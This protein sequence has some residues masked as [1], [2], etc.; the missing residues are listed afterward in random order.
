MPVVSKR[1][2]L[3][4]IGVSLALI[5]SIIFITIQAVGSLTKTNRASAQIS[6]T[7][8]V[9]A[10]DP[11]GLPIYNK[12]TVV[13]GKIGQLLNK[14]KL[15]VLSTQNGWAFVTDSNNKG[16]VSSAA[17]RYDSVFPVHAAKSITDD[18][19]KLQR[20]TWKGSYTKAQLNA[21]LAPHFTQDFI[22][23]YV[24]QLFHPAGTTS[25]G[26]TLYAIEK[27][28]IYGYAIDQFDWAATQDPQPPMITHYTQNGQEVLIISQYHLNEESGNHMSTLYLTRKDQT[29]TWKVN[30]YITAY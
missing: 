27:T 20:K 21:M 30:D 16:Y 14:T 18:V 5:F 9:A 4:Q 8:V 12:A 10:D 1:K 3:T 13:S 2:M 28:E 24:K 19:I 11:S 6:Q 17:L 22:D 25:D 26:T 29:G 7:A 15:N 23:K